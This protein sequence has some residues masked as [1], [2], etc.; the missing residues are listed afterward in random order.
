MAGPKS[1]GGKKKYTHSQ[2]A[3]RVIEDFRRINNQKNPLRVYLCRSCQHYHIGSQP[4]K[5][6]ALRSDRLK[7]RLAKHEY[8]PDD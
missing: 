7:H 4:P 5:A 8:L 2:H 3:R 6:T 1:C